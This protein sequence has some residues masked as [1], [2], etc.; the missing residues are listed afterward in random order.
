[1]SRQSQL[2]QRRK[3]GTIL[4][5]M[6]CIRVSVKML[7]CAMSLYILSEVFIMLFQFYLLSY[8]ACIFILL[9][10]LLEDFV[11]TDSPRRL[12]STRLDVLLLTR[13]TYYEKIRSSFEESRKSHKSLLI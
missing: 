12:S 6:P 4:L 13:R 3:M 10:Q 1:M 7:Q 9:T 11:I 5:G 8:F 2:L